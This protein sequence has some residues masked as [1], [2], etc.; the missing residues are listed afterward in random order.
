MQKQE[1]DKAIIEMADMVVVLSHMA[2]SL[3]HDLQKAVDLK[4]RVNR[5]RTWAITAEGTG[6]HTSEGVSQA[7]SENVV[8][9]ST[10]A[11]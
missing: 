8:Q 10:P 3:G 6:T 5:A 4:M 2:A 9:S 1:Y 11:S 7:P